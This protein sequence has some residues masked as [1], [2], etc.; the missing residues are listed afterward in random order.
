M[1]ESLDCTLYD[2]RLEY[3]RG[4]PRTDLYTTSNRTLVVFFES[5]SRS[6]YMLSNFTLVMHVAGGEEDVICTPALPALGTVD[7]FVHPLLVQDVDQHVERWTLHVY[8]VHPSPHVDDVRTMSMKRDDGGVCLFTFQG[9]TETVPAVR[10]EALLSAL[11][12]AFQ[13]VKQTVVCA[14]KRK[15]PGA[16]AVSGADDGDGSVFVDESFTPFPTE[17][18]VAFLCDGVEE[19]KNGFTAPPDQ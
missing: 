4:A 13:I 19:S 8:A 12:A 14:I 6:A 2:D 10:S 11:T 16:A 7:G 18:A 15:S 1:F 17:R 5:A 9:G 3:Q